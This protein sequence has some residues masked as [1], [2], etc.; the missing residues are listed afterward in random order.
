MI[1]LISDL[2]PCVPTYGLAL[3]EALF[4]AVRCGGEDTLRLWVNERAVII[5]R[6]Q[7]I[8]AEVDLVQ[9]RSL[10]IPVLRRISGGGAVY[11]YPGNL[12]VS[13]FLKDGRPLGGAKQTFHSCGEAIARSL[14]ELGIRIAVRKNSL[15]LSEKKIA[16]AAQA[17]RGN[18]LLY[19]TTLLVK[20]D[21]VPMERLLRAAHGDYHPIGVPSRSHPTTAIAESSDRT[22]SFETIGQRIVTQCCRLLHRSTYKGSLTE[23]ERAHAQELTTEKYETVEWNHCR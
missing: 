7:S 5:G 16:G 22:L 14:A 18:A 15:F 8:A 1:R 21:K 6:S 3:E 19:H 10:R 23:E 4:E 17:R 13:V 2:A 9:A 20:P 11:H 12:N